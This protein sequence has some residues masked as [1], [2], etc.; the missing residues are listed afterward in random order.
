M[1]YLPSSC[2]V[3]FFLFSLFHHLPCVSS[4]QELGLCEAQFQCGNITVGF[5][6]WGGNRHKDCGHPL[7]ELRCS[8]NIS[9]LAISNHLYHVLHIDQISNTLR[10]SS[11]EFQGTFC[12]STFTATTLPPQ[13]FEL[14]PTFKNLTVFYLC[15]PKRSYHSSYTCSGWGPISVSE[16][17]DYHKSCL[18]SFTINVPKSFVP[19]EKELNLTHIESALRE[20]FEV[21]LKIDEKACQDCSS[22]EIC[23][24]NNTTQVFCK[25][26]SSSACNSLH[27][28]SPGSRHVLEVLQHKPSTYGVAA[29]SPGPIAMPDFDVEVEYAPLSPGSYDGTTLPPQV[30]DLSPTFKN[31]TVFYLCDPKLSYHSSYTCPGRGPISVS[32]NLDYHK[33]C[34]DSFKIN[35]PKSFVPE[36]KELNLTHI[37][38]ALREGF[39]VKLKIDEKA[40]QDCSSHEICGFNNTTQVCCKEASSSASNTLHPP[41]PGSRHVLEV[42]QHK[43]S[44]YGV[45]A[46]SPGPI[47]M[48]DFD[49]EVEYAPLSPGSYDGSEDDKPRIRFWVFL[50]VVLLLIL[51]VVIIYGHIRKSNDMGQ[52]NIPNPKLIALIP[53]K[54][55]SYEELR[56]ITN[57]FA[58]VVGRGGFGT[59]YRGIFSDGRMVAVKVLKDLMGNSGE[60]FINEVASMS[61]TSHV[62]IVTLLGFCYEGYKRAI[63]YEFMENGS[64]DKFLSS[65]KS[66][67]IDWR[68]LY[69]IALG[70]ARGLEYLHHGCRTRIVHFDIKPQNVLLDD[71][72]SPKVSDFGLAKLC[73]RKES[74]LSLLDTRGT[75]GY[76]APEVFSR[77]YGS[78]SYKSDVYSYGMLVLEIIGARNK[79][80]TGDTV[81]STSSMYFP[82]WIY[83]DLE[84]A[85]NGKRIENGIS[86]EEDEIAKKMT[87]V[88]LWCIQ[89]WPSDRPTMN[90]VVEMMEGNL[91]ALGVPPKPVFQQIP[92]ANLQESSTFSEDSSAYTEDGCSI[93]VA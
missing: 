85:D 35:V 26:V 6:F 11:S 65:K 30:F 33:S 68:E 8:N 66:S 43:P 84:K 67:N 56:R 61:Q 32:E 2:L 75:I 88:G 78:V 28:P 71:N 36:E 25:E 21:K 27:P 69:G 31:L 3:L 1:Y 24:F 46:P 18:D 44:T 62:N 5:P 9:S 39:E 37:E 59:V 17:L 91:D 81:S 38:S 7:L 53:L 57:S 19:E 40:C 20:G 29:P 22:H 50:P 48:P 72:L 4:K 60:D 47:A 80:S 15:D 13:I 79:S 16:N 14:S 54:Q 12:N 74:L 10:L 89:P 34:L 82:E 63:I 77:V 70:V 73:E 64:L 49:V 42:L 58:E 45:A 92:T 83:R 90:R 51:F 87:M 52:Q 23:G 41:S 55:Y 76:I 93:N 86:S